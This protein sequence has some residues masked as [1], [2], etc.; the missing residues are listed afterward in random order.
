MD[1]TWAEW[2][3][4]FADVWLSLTDQ[5]AWRT[6]CCNS[7]NHALVY[8]WIDAHHALTHCK[9]CPYQGKDESWGE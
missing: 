6:K 1:Y 7:G 5:P 4:W 2:K 3:A 8:H 9:F